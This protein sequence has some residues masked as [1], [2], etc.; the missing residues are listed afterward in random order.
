MKRGGGGGGRGHAN[1]CCPISLQV[2][3]GTIFD[4]ILVTDDIEQATKFRD[5]TWG[6]MK[7]KEKEMFDEIDAAKKAE[8]AAARAEMDAEKD[9]L[10]DEDDYED[11]EEEEDE[12]EDVEDEDEEHDEL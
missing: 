3:S 10:E 1:P 5:E 6:A 8:E 11:E 2:K 12:Y 7:D 4:N 9:D